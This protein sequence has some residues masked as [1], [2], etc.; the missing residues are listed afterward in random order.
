[1]MRKIIHQFSGNKDAEN[2]YRSNNKEYCQSKR[3]YI[4]SKYEPSLKKKYLHMRNENDKH[5]SRSIEIFFITFKTQF[6]TS[7]VKISTALQSNI[8]YNLFALPSNQYW[9]ETNQPKN[10]LQI[11]TNRLNKTRVALSAFHSRSTIRPFF[12]LCIS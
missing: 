2:C 9:Q 4:W 1:M 3:S 11:F 12:T 6:K 7:K 5:L 8:F 10:C